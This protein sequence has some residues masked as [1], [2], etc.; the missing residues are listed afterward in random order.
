M[1]VRVITILFT[2]MAAAFALTRAPVLATSIALAS[3][4]CMVTLVTFFAIMR[5]DVA[6]R[7]FWVSLAFTI[8]A[9]ILGKIFLTSRRLPLLCTGVAT[10][11][12]FTSHFIRNGYKFVWET[13][14]GDRKTSIDKIENI[15][16]ATILWLIVKQIERMIINIL[17]FFRDLPKNIM[18][19]LI[20]MLKACLR[21]R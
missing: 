17:V 15:A 10:L 2:I 1:Y 18:L 3:V 9:M 13:A 19:L 8:V 11:A 12:F 14:D 21:R 20:R 5:M 4:Y 6:A 16:G 7:D